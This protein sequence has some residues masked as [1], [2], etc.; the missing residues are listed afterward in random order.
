[1]NIAEKTFAM[2]LVCKGLYTP[3]MVHGKSGGMIWEKQ[4]QKAFIIEWASFWK[5][6]QKS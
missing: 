4:R 5:G 6:K 2:V 3:D 1:M